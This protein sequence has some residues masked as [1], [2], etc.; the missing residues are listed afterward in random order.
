MCGT[1]VRKSSYIDF[2]LKKLR[3]VTHTL[4]RRTV[5]F[6]FTGKHAPQMSLW[7]DLVKAEMA[8]R[9]KTGKNGDKRNDQ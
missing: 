1:K 5:F 4:W 8:N 7:G 9:Q 3:E 6:C 2:Q